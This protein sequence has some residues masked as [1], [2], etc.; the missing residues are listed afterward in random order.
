MPNHVAERLH[1][2]SL[3]ALLRARDLTHLRVRRYG[4]LLVVESGPKEDAVAHARLRRQGAHIW[5]LEMPTHTGAWETTPFRGLLRE[6][7][8]LLV[9]DF[10]WALA[11]MA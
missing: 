6:M 8:D 4:V 11:H 9:T 7:V 3:E 10:P 2:E 5:G 1:A